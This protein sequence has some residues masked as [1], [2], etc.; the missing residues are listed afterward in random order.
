MEQVNESHL[1]AYYHIIVI[2]WK[3]TTGIL[4][5]I[6]SLCVFLKKRLRPAT[7]GSSDVYNRGRA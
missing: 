1:L 2:G 5:R 7:A 6:L 3:G 4:V